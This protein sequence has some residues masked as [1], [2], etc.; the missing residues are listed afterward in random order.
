MAKKR[1]KLAKIEFEELMKRC[2]TDAAV[3]DK[4]IK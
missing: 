2:A 4:E 1:K 3:V